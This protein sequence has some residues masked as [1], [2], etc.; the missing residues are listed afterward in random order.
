V[1]NRGEIFNMRFTTDAFQRKG[2]KESVGI[3]SMS[4][5]GNMSLEHLV[6]RSMTN[7]NRQTSDAFMRGLGNSSPQLKQFSN[8]GK[9]YKKGK[10]GGLTSYTFTVPKSSI[11]TTRGVVNS[12]GGT[13][14]MASRGTTLYMLMD[15]DR[16]KGAETIRRSFKA[17]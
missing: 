12:P 8:F 10:W 15:T 7:E 9:N 13:M 1:S 3:I 5:P 17:Q 11:R 16:S 14:I 4:M 2:S 6:E